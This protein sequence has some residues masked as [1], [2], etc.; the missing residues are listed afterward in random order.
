MVLGLVLVSLGGIAAVER[1]DPA[2]ASCHLPPE[3]TFVARSGRPPSDLASAHAQAQAS[4]A[5][6]CV[7][8]HGGPGLGGRVA[9]LQMGARDLWHYVRGDFTVLGSTY[10][11]ADTLRHPVPDAT[12]LSCHLPVMTDSGFENHFH[13]RLSDPERPAELSC[14]DC[15]AAHQPTDPAVVG[16]LS[17]AVAQE[18]EVC[19]EVMGGPM[20]LAAATPGT[21]RR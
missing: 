12:C 20:G 7:D 8:C 11:P 16:G 17:R 10:L 1:H 3:A 18:C 2:C 9:S 21:E 15:H 19:H 14:T 5:V 4:A 6:R 13:S